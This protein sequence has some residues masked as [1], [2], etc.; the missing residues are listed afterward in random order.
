[1]S[2]VLR[3]LMSAP[4][5]SSNYSVTPNRESGSLILS[6]LIKFILFGEKIAGELRVGWNEVACC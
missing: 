2:K 5:N 1:M 3:S 4:L 6:L